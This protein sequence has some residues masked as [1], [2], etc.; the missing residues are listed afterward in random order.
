MKEKNFFRALFLLKK[1]EEKIRFCPLK[2]IKGKY[3]KDKEGVEFFNTIDEFLTYLKEN[4][5]RLEREGYN[6]YF[7]PAFFKPE[8]KQGGNENVAGSGCVFVDVDFEESISVKKVREEV[9][10]FKE[11]CPLKPSMIVFSGNKGFHSYWLFENRLNA[12][13]FAEVQ[14]YWNTYLRENVEKCVDPACKD[15][16]RLIRLPGSLHSTSQKRCQ[17]LEFNPNLKYKLSDFQ[18]FINKVKIAEFDKII[19]EGVIDDDKIDI[20]N[21]VEIVKP[22]WVKGRRQNLALYLSGFLYKQGVKKQTTQLIISQICKETRDEEANQRLSAIEETYQKEK[23]E[24]SGLAGIKELLENELSKDGIFYIFGKLKEAIG[25]SAKSFE[26]KNYTIYCDSYKKIWKLTE[27]GK[28][29]LETEKPTTP[30]DLKKKLGEYLIKLEDSE[31]LELFKK[32]EAQFELPTKSGE[33]KENTI[34]LAEDSGQPFRIFDKADVV[35]DIYFV[36]IYALDKDYKYIP[37]IATSKGEIIEIQD[38]EQLLLKRGYKPKEIPDEEKYCFFEYETGKRRYFFKL[39]NKPAFDERFGIT[40]ISTNAIKM[41]LEK[42][43]I[44]K[45]QLF[46]DI[47][48]IIKQYFD[49]SD[50]REYLVMGSF[51]I[52]SYIE[53]TLQQTIYLL[54]QGQ[55]DT[56]KSTLQRLL[57]KLQLYGFFGG[58]KSIAVL[59][60]YLDFYSCKL[61]LDEFEKLDEKSKTMAVGVLN[62][63]LYGDGTYDFVNMEQKDI[64]KSIISLNTF[65]FKSFSCNNL[66]GF[67]RSFLSRCYNLICVRQNRKLKNILDKE[68]IEKDKAIFQNIVD[69]LFV[70]CLLNWKKIIDSIKKEKEILEQES[71]FG[72]VTDRNSVILGII[73]HFIPESYKDIKELLKNKEGLS[74]QEELET[75]NGAVLWSLCELFKQQ[76]QETKTTITVTNKKIVEIMQE[77]MGFSDEERGKYSK[78]VGKLCKRLNLFKR[79][80]QIKRTKEGRIY[81]IYL[82]D[83]VDIL[84]RNNYQ[85]ILQELNDITTQTTQTTSLV[86]DVSD[87]SDVLPNDS[88]KNTIQKF[89]QF[90]LENQEKEEEFGVPIE[91]I[92]EFWDNLPEKEKNGELEH[93][94][95]FCEKEGIIYKPKGGYYATL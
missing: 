46:N 59:V 71:I 12:E 92:R 22:Y 5:Q 86:G 19:P 21:V 69:R 54:L 73:N 55:E 85:D 18:K 62:S 91:K 8:A 28:N 10:K 13:Q 63:G 4:L 25:S 88:L 29:I 20:K 40:N 77:Q 34:Q 45:K 81:T 26:F 11:K 43:Q 53:S 31:L 2:K 82:S 16:Q 6:I 7:N 65:G 37:L 80:D 83:F 15:I 76:N 61:G 68:T 84:R 58:K 93:F 75:V 36:L 66:Y 52:L 1:T 87:V 72:R 70:Y 27:N 32:L 44:D 89:K 94:L 60:R 9:A 51:V 47:L 3:V 78:K 56:G 74:K 35:D 67:D 49:H 50:E 57:S 39:K 48:T 30:K 38:N 17:I 41:L 95:H 90:L 33:T 64:K 79:P 24:V 23:K 42:K 14:R